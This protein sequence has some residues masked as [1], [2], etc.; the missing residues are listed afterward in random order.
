VGG[1]H[2]PFP[3]ALPAST[4]RAVISPTS[5][6]G[7]TTNRCSFCTAACGSATGWRRPRLGRGLAGRALP[8]IAG[9][10]SPGERWM[11]G[12]GLRQCV[13]GLPYAALFPKGDT[14]DG[15]STRIPAS[16]SRPACGPVQCAPRGARHEPPPQSATT[17]ASNGKL[18]WP[19]SGLAGCSRL[20]HVVPCSPMEWLIEAG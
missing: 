1:G 4:D 10:I 20:P 6:L 17:G 11:P 5:A 3:P 13:I 18:V 16:W 15:R 2:G 14:V 9:S 8:I 19:P 12:T 7:S